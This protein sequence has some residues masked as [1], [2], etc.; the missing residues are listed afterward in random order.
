MPMARRLSELVRNQRSACPSLSLV[1]LGKS[2]THRADREADRLR[3]SVYALKKN[4]VEFDLVAPHFD[5]ATLVLIGREFAEDH[6][7]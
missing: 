7:A 5:G 4:E 6:N 2:K 1:S 3:L